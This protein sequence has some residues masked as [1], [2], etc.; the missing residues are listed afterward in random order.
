MKKIILSIL[1][2]FV[3][4]HAFSQNKDVEEIKKL[5]SDWLNL[6]VTKDTAAFSKIFAEDFVLIN[7]AGKKVTKQE[8]VRNI[9]HQDLKSVTIDSLDVKILTKD[10]GLITC[11]ITFMAMDNGKE[12]TGRTCYQDAYIKRNGRWFAVAAHVTF[13]GGN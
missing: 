7:P 6:S 8:G 2:L 12:T 1:S 13:L 9:L 4:L 11:Y 5:N 10:V 3:L